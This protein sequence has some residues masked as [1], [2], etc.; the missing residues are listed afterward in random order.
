M[1]MIE[2]IFSEERRQLFELARSYRH[3][4]ILFTCVELGIFDIL[5]ANPS[6]ASDVAAQ[7]GADR[8]GVELLLNAATA[9]GWLQKRE[10]LFSNSTLAKRHLTSAGI[11]RSLRL[12]SAFYRR[13]GHLSEAVRTGS[14]P[15]EN[16]RDEQPPEWVRT[17]IYAL[18]DTC[19]SVAPYITE[20]IPLPTDQP[21]RLLDVGGGHAGYSIEFA[22]KY[23]LLTATVF[24]LPRV[25]P[26]AQEIIAEAGLSERIKVQE[27]DFQREEL[28]SGYDVALVFG[29]LN[30][31]PPT[32]RP[33]LLRKVFNALQPGGLIVLR[34]FVLQADRAGPPEAAIFALQ[35]LLAT[36]AGGLDTQ[37]D[38]ESWL[39]SAGFLPPQKI[40]LPNFSDVPLII[41]QKP[42]F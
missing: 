5:S 25:V 9:L 33:A 27:G 35:M 20:A 10:G 8:R 3:S 22:R 11:G 4:Q 21:L 42:R 1:E 34:D 2:D 7:I 37:E 36:E 18:Y 24:E 26:I 15:E 40:D 17:F 28:G 23:P 30:G 31:E 39:N 12:E 41:A 29:V 19:R 38:W 14:R 6:T 16:R 13:W 32:G